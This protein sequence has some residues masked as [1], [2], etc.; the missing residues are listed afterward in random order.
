MIARW[1]SEVRGVVA[2]L[3]TALLL[4]AAAGVAAAQDRA[5]IRRHS[6]R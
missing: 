6:Q 4:P 3:M 1:S 2:V 5:S